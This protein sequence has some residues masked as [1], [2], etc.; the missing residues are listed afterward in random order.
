MIHS[1]FY[2]VHD[3]TNG[4]IVLLDSSVLSETQVSALLSGEV[5]T[6]GNQSFVTAVDSM[7]TVASDSEVVMHRQPDLNSTFTPV[8][9]SAEALR[10]I[11]IYQRDRYW[12][13]RKINLSLSDVIIDAIN[14]AMAAVNNG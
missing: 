6:I 13:S 4:N 1:T 9:V 8:V 14:V 5:I 10:Q 11:G 2:P 3:R 12:K 7:L